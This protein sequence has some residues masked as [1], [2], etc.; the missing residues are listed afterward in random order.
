MRAVVQ[1]VREARVQVDGETVGEIGPGCVVLIGV[2]TTDTQAE[3]TALAE[4]VANLRI[5][6]DDE[7]KMNRSILDTGGAVL[8]VSQFTLYGDTRKGRRPSFID[9]APPEQAEVLYDVFNARLRTLGIPVQT[10]RFRAMMVVEIHNDGPV[11]LLLDTE[12]L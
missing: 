2:R 6:E 11:T 3:A 10:G 1:R 12:A 4:K 8:S 9:A 5:M 7:G